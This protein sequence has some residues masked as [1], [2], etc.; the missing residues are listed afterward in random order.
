VYARSQQ[1]VSRPY[2][3]TGKLG[4]TGIGESSLGVGAAPAAPGDT[5]GTVSRWDV[6][7]FSCPSTGVFHARGLP[8]PCSSGTM[9]LRL[10]HTGSTHRLNTQL[11]EIIAGHRL[12][13]PYSTTT[14]TRPLLELYRSTAYTTLGQRAPPEMAMVV[15][16]DANLVCLP[17]PRRIMANKVGK[18]GDSKKTIR[19]SMASAALPCGSNMERREVREAPIMEIPKV[20]R[21]GIPK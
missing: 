7:A 21:G 17:C 18:M 20:M 11:E 1:D 3:A 10:L 4:F 9:T 16:A 13:T 2:V 19:I 6:N 14:T 12:D 5:H 8:C 15:A